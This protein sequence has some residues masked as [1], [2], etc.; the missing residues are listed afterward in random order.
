MVNRSFDLYKSFRKR[1]IFFLSENGVH[2][3]VKHTVRTRCLKF[4][5]TVRLASQTFVNSVQI[6]FSTTNFQYAAAV[7]FSK[8]FR[9]MECAERVD[10]FRL[11]S[12]LTATTLEI[13]TRRQINSRIDSNNG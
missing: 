10:K 4:E 12:N 11:L 8:M 3:L 6:K 9:A 7:K 5:E 1:N 13:T 2:V